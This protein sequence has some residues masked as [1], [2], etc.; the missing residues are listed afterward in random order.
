MILNM[1][2]LVG[3]IIYSNFQLQAWAIAKKKQKKPLRQS[4][5]ARSGNGNLGRRLR[6]NQRAQAIPRFKDRSQRPNRLGPLVLHS[7]L[8]R[9]HSRNPKRPQ[10]LLL[11]ISDLSPHRRSLRRPIQPSIRHR[12]RNQPRRSRIRHLPDRQPRNP[13]RDSRPYDRCD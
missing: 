1:I 7:P 3:G 5:R 10:I 2:A 13:I 8:L 9:S 4:Q 12:R 11:S 6:E